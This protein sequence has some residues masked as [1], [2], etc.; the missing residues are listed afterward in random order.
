MTGKPKKA[1]LIVIT[2][3]YAPKGDE[4]DE[5]ATYWE[6][7]LNKAGDLD[8][9]FLDVCDFLLVHGHSDMQNDIKAA[10]ED[11]ILKEFEISNCNWE[12]WEQVYCFVHAREKYRKQIKKIP[13]IEDHVYEYGSRGT[14]L[15][16]PDLLEQ[17][18]IKIKNSFL[19]DYIGQILYKIKEKLRGFRYKQHLLYQVKE[20]LLQLRFNL[21]VFACE[22]DD[23]FEC[24]ASEDIKSIVEDIRKNLTDPP[25]L[26]CTSDKAG[27][28]RTH[29]MFLK[30]DASQSLITIFATDL[31]GNEPLCAKKVWKSIL[32]TGPSSETLN[33]SKE[34]R[35]ELEQIRKDFENLSKSIEAVLN[36]IKSNFGQKTQVSGSE[37]TEE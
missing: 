23:T 33:L 29:E 21:E 19:S 8:T 24:E 2:R 25:L 31:E 1:L 20:R 4:N 15:A 18:K 12:H 3:T 5:Y 36:W 28:P 32:S 13:N 11:V 37:K 26:L 35:S 34:A 10:I 9:N 22:L 30:L 14:N 17:I 7:E 6:G 16:P 27:I